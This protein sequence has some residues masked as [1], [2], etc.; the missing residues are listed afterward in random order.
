MIVLTPDRKEEVRTEQE[1]V[2]EFEAHRDHGYAQ[3]ILMD[4]GG[5]YL[6]AIGEG[7]GPYTIEWFPTHMTGTHLR[8]TGEFKSSEVMAVLLEI[9]RGSV[10]WSD[11]FGCH[12]VENERPPLPARLLESLRGLLGKHRRADGS[13]DE[14]SGEQTA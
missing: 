2:A 9:F 10:V 8:A 7:F 3:F 13:S 5:A 12:E 14:G 6:S 11:S 1:L 4:D